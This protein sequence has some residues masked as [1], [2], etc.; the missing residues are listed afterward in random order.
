M[1]RGALVVNLDY[2]KEN[3]QSLRRFYPPKEIIFML[4]AGGYGHGAEE[5]S[6]VAI[7]EGISSFGLASLDEAISLRKK[8]LDYRSLTSGET[9]RLLVFSDLEFFQKDALTFYNCYGITPVISS[10]YA[11][12]IF[13]ES[14]LFSQVPLFLKMNTGM[15][16]LGISGEGDELEMCIKLLKSRGRR[17]ISHLMTHFANASEDD[18]LFPD[19]AS[20]IEKFRSLLGA[21]SAAGIQVEETSLANSGAIEKGATRNSINESH[22][23]PGLMLYGPSSLAEKDRSWEGKL[24]SS[25]SSSVVHRRKIREGDSVGYGGER[26]PEDGELVIVPL[27]Y[28][29]GISQDYRGV[30]LPHGGTFFAKIN[31]DMAQIFFPYSERRQVPREGEKVVFWENLEQ[32]YTLVSQTKTTSYELFCQLSSRI[33]RVYPL[34]AAASASSKVYTK[35]LSE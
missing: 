4:K 3:I 11:L 26:V 17:A 7:N 27:G 9:C 16:R 31:M 25:L 28:G 8:L 5:L 6:L 21:F 13:L 33:K 23:R 12:K 18:T 15:N 14:R 30:K 24:I 34:R 20:Q 29:D 35:V 2:F 19:P 1:S 10:L 32:F 22:I